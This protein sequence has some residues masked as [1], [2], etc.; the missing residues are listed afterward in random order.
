[1]IL[2]KT[3]ALLCAA[4]LLASCADVPE[5]AKDN[6]KVTFYPYWQ[7]AFGL[8]PLAEHYALIN[9]VDGRVIYNEPKG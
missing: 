2:R 6:S 8:Q 3:I 4:A 7:L 5:G 1:M 9:A